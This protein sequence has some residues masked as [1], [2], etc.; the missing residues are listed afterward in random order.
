MDTLICGH[1]EGKA[2]QQVRPQLT[3]KETKMFVQRRRVRPGSESQAARSCSAVTP[4]A[5]KYVPQEN[6][7]SHD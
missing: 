4:P 3:E 1:D 6:Q 7:P 2:V 5:F